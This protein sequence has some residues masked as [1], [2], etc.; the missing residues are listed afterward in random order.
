MAISFN[1]IPTNTRTPGV[2][3][4]VDNSRALQGLAANPHK[5]LIVGT[6]IAAGTAENAVIQ[7]ITRD[8]L[9]DGY[10]GAGSLL[11]RMINQF[12][13]ANP[14]T[15]LHAMSLSGG[16]V[17]ASNEIRFSIALSHAGGIVSTNNEELK[18][19][20]NGTKVYT[21]LTSD[22]SLTDVVSAIQTTV[23]NNSQLPVTASISTGSGI[24]ILN[25]VDSGVHGN[26]LDARLNY[27]AGES[28]PTC[29]ADSVVIGGFSGGVGQPDLGDVWPVIQNDTYQY[30][31]QPWIDA[32]NLTEI[33]TELADRFKP[34]EDKQG[35]GFTAVRATQASATTLGN[36][37]NSP[38]NT[39]LA[40]NDSPTD[41]AEWAAVLGAIAGFNLNN[42]PA[43]PLHFL[44]LS[45]ILPPPTN[46]VF[47]QA[48]R[49]IL[50]F[51]GIAT[52]T[53]NAGSVYL[54]R[55]I[56]SYQTNAAGITD[57]SYLDVN[58]LA[59]LE[60]IRYQYKT[61]MVTRFIVPRFKLA[62]DTFPIQ[63]GQFITSPRGIRQEIISL[64]TLLRD[65]GLIENLQ[66]F[67]DNLIVERDS[68]DKNRVNVLLPPDLVN[69][70]RVL[71]SLLQF[72]L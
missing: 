1:N 60:E 42:D 18:L 47:T 9:A 33:E 20:I 6:K 50:L 19:L 8:N 67:I 26:Y 29:F 5:A 32:A 63:P 35:H 2:Y 48:E 25:A 39:I 13:A 17:K 10:Y 57:A 7:Q 21:T 34:L 52:W 40:A 68:S 41:P 55:V 14:N 69:Q 37:R 71:G 43:R 24:L 36:S 44:Q 62:D 3:V 56:T 53:E 23:N 38:H 31:V 49:N 12:K 16:T 28:D 4:E 30:I 15:E 46:N 61:R 66:D 45:N 54:E 11:A 27:Y 72:I 70:F 51:D 65:N 59:T 22:W 64:F 58:T